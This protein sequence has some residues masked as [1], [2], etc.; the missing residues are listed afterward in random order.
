MRTQ[1]MEFL[2]RPTTTLI[3]ELV[4]CHKIR[5]TVRTLLADKHPGKLDRIYIERPDEVVELQRDSVCIA[6]LLDGVNSIAKR[7]F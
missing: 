1:E 2:I 6:G 7:L 3:W 4:D 5:G